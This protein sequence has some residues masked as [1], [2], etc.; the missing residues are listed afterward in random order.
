[1]CRHFDSPFSYILYSFILTS[2]VDDL[3]FCFAAFF[4][5]CDTQACVYAFFEFGDVR[6]DAYHAACV[7]EV[8]EC[9]HGAVQGVG[10]EGAEA[11]VNEHGIKTDAALPGLDNV[12]KAKSQRQGCQEGFS[13]GKGIG[14]S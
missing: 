5:G 4:C 9:I 13:A 11:F 6:N 12:G 14:W 7:L 1:M 10:V 8:D 2:S 3:E